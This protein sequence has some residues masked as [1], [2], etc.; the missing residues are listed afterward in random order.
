MLIIGYQLLMVV[1]PCVRCF[2]T[3]LACSTLS[4]G[5]LS[6]SM[7]SSPHVQGIISQVDS[8]WVVWSEFA[9]AE[10]LFP[11]LD[12]TNENRNL[13]LQKLSMQPFPGVFNPWNIFQ[14]CFFWSKDA[15]ISPGLWAPSGSSARAWSF[16][17]ATSK[18]SSTCEVFE[19]KNPSVEKTWQQK[20]PSG[21]WQKLNVDQ[22]LFPFSVAAIVIYSHSNPCFFG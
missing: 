15:E 10:C 12:F 19:G 9:G 5:S 14:M 3:I 16:A 18:L 22:C 4:V 8:W 2:W 21:T 13:P 6:K 7:L 1:V 20:F 17:S 11:S